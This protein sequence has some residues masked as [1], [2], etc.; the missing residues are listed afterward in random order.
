MVMARSVRVIFFGTP[1]FAVPTLDA[2]LASRHEVV[3]VVTQPDKP[4]GRG[5]SVSHAPVKARAL[6]ANIPILQPPTMKDPAFV[7][8]LA[9]FGS[10]L[11]VV[12]AFGKILTDVVLATPRMGMINVHASLL[13]RYRG[14]APVHRAVIAGEH[15][16][17][18]TIM[19]V[20]KTLDAGPMISTV[21]HRISPD[22]TSDEVER[23]LARLGADLLV[24]AVDIMADGPIVETPQDE[25][26]ATYAA[27][28]TK[29][30]GLVDWSRSSEDVHNLVRGLHP[31]PHACSFAGARRVILLRTRP[32]VGNTTALP[33]G[34]IIAASGDDLRVA[35]GSGAIQIL[36]L[37]GE[38]T[39]PMSARDFLAGRHLTAGQ[40]LTSAP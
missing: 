17:G 27:R 30:D 26:D 6:L 34:T 3:A 10:D 37:Q 24:S 25:R 14:A 2:L 31:W 39:R 40:R 4:R 7:E 23:E 20:V 33:P 1:A 29:A 9:T 22:E 28:L 13:P 36:S 35:C 5:Q 19:R 15:E 18:V 16:T 21:R 11:G 8:T 38:G 32:A 12:A